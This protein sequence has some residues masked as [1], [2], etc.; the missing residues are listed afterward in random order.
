MDGPAHYRK[1]EKLLNETATSGPSI[2]ERDTW[3]QRQA[4]VHAILA[5]TA[6]ARA[7]HKPGAVYSIPIPT[8]TPARRGCPGSTL[9]RPGP[10]PIG[11]SSGGNRAATPLTRCPRSRKHPGMTASESPSEQPPGDDTALLT[12]AL[13]H[14]WARYDGRRNRAFQVLN[15]YLVAAAILFTAY[16]SAINGKH[17]AVACALAIAGLGLTAL[18]AGI[19]LYEVKAADLARPAVAELQNRGRRQ[20]ETRSA[21]C[22]HIPDRNNW[23]KTHCQHP[24]V[25]AGNPAQHQRTDICGNSLTR[26]TRHPP[27]L[28]PAAWTV[29]R[30]D[31]HVNGTGTR[32]LTLQEIEAAAAQVQRHVLQAVDHATRDTA[33]S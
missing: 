18:T 9:P 10:V 8:R 27:Q 23:A 17:Y 16:T 2:S 22:D 19:V 7:T 25:R 13:N 11:R 5:L 15:Y 24:H 30:K 21:P 3:Q 14:Y 1:A 6:Q 31:R 26:S 32:P 29:N 28:S 4:L 12:A 20:A 33:K